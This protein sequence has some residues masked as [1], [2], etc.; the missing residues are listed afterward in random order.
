ML[1]FSNSFLG[2]L[3]NNRE[4]N[5]L[6]LHKLGFGMHQKQKTEYAHR[7][8]KTK[9]FVHITPK[10]KDSY[11]IKTHRT[12]LITQTKMTLQFNTSFY[13]SIVLCFFLSPSARKQKKS[14]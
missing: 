8:K 6:N 7:Q 2:K 10:Q 13:I 11:Q 3:Q 1:F 5:I 4:K 12:L 14:L 9:D